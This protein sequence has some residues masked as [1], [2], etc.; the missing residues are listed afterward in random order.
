ML[1]D[2]RDLAQNGWFI[3]RK[4]LLPANK[5]GKVLTWYLEPNSTDGWKRIP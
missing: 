4:V 3:I 2:G 1:F 5:T